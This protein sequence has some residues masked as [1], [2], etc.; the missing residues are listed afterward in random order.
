MTH[1]KTLYSWTY[2]SPMGKI[3]IWGTKSKLYFVEFLNSSKFSFNQKKRE[4]SFKQIIEGLTPPIEKT[5]HWLDVYFADHK[6]KTLPPFELIGSDFEK[7]VWEVLKDIP[8]GETW[9]YGQIAEC[10]DRPNAARAVGSA[11][12]KNPIS[13]LVPC[14]RVIGSSGQIS[15]YA[16]GVDRKKQLI[17]V[18]AR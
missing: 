17:Q 10:I 5:V 14:H 18:E 16:G 12:G 3:G 1:R 9:T 2:Y 4:E 13:L 6:V 7:E 11:I 8:P 15:G